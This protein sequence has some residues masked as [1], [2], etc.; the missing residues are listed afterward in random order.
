MPEP[1]PRE[2]CA[3]TTDCGHLDDCAERPAAEFLGRFQKD[4]GSQNTTE[5]TYI[6]HRPTAVARG[7]YRQVADRLKADQS[8]TLL[9]GISRTPPRAPSTLERR[10]CQRL[11]LRC[12]DCLPRRDWC[13]LCR[14]VSDEMRTAERLVAVERLADDLWSES[15]QSHMA[16]RDAGITQD[17]VYR[18]RAA[19]GL[20][21]D[22][23]GDVRTPS[24]VDGGVS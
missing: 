15:Q 18:L 13:D 8:E 22:P 16:I 4:A 19:I 3:T 5:S 2:C 21:E 24:G 6:R 1:E 7:L 23:D 17:I 14:E 9:G 10:D 12:I 20:P 11:G